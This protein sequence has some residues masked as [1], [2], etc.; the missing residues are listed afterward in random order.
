MGSNVR[1]LLIGID[2]HV[3][4]AGK[5]FYHYYGAVVEKIEEASSSQK[6]KDGTH[7]EKTRGPRGQQRR[8]HKISRWFDQ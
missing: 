3:I 1:G 4:V 7:T 8:C 2:L 6:A 5:R